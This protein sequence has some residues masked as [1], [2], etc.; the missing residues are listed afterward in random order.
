MYE[1][2]LAVVK[3]SKVISVKEIVKK[4]GFKRGEVIKALKFLSLKGKL[5]YMNPRIKFNS[6][7]E[8][9]ILRK[10]CNTKGG[11]NGIFIN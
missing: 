4:T 8:N 5:I 2:V 1:I 3:R 7:C 10:L 6:S 9:C 11:K